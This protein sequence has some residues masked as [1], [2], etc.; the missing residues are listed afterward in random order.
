MPNLKG[1]T[2]VSTLIQKLKDG[3]SEFS[4]ITLY[5]FLAAGIDESDIPK[6]LHFGA[7]YFGAEGQ[8]HVFFLI[9]ESISAG[10]AMN[11]EHKTCSGNKTQWAGTSKSDAT[12]WGPDGASSSWEAK[13][14]P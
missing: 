8:P 10:R 7:V 1:W 6:D 3:W 2:P 11:Y 9:R 13:V 14:P 4:Q 5:D 12:W